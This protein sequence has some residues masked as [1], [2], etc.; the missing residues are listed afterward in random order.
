MQPSSFLVNI[1]QQPEFLSAVSSSD[2][3]SRINCATPKR[4]SSLIKEQDYYAAAIT[5]KLSQGR[6]D[7]ASE[8]LKINTDFK[9]TQNW[10][11]VSD[12]SPLGRVLERLRGRWENG[13]GWRKNFRFRFIVERDTGR[14]VRCLVPAVRLPLTTAV[15]AAAAAVANADERRHLSP[16]RRSRNGDDDGAG[17]AASN[18]AASETVA[19]IA[20][21]NEN[22]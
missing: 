2:I 13:D 19:S 18:N 5:A 6:Y 4:L 20:K 12:W 9:S 15:A 22:Q 8:A 10:V 21:K 16:D 3:E 11:T 14:S 7:S 17:T 1:A